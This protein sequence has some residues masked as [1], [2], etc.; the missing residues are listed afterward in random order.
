M[1][2]GMTK[3]LNQILRRSKVKRNLYWGRLGG[4]VLLNGKSGEGLNGA[5]SAMV[6]LT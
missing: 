5:D 4:H 3:I 6:C 1:T 2:S